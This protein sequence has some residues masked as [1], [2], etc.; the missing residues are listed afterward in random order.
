MSTL[1]VKRTRD[2]RRSR[3]QFAAVLVTITLGVMLFAASYDAYR[4]LRASYEGTYERLAFAD[5]TVTGG[6]ASFADSAVALPGV[7]EVAERRQADIPIRVAGDVLLG[8]VV[9]MP[10]D[11]QPPVDRIDVT[12]G[13]YLSSDTPSGVVVET[14]MA[15]ELG[16]RVGEPVGILVGSTWRPAEV[17]GIAVSPEY[18][19][20][21]RS[22]QDVFPA[23]GTFGVIF[24]SNDLLEGLPETAAARQTLILYAPAAD[25]SATDDAVLGAVRA[26]DGA[27]V[28][29]QADQPS[30]A[31]LQL[32]VQGF[33][34]LSIMFPALFL[35]AAG[36]AAY[37]LLTRIVY[38]QRGQIGTLRAN[39]LS[40]RAVSRHYLSF[41]V[42]LGA[43]GAVIGVALGVTFGWAMTGLYTKG[44]GIP[45][46]VRELHPVTPVVGLLFGL[47]CG[48]LAALVPARAVSKISPAQ[49][50]RVDTPTVA[51]RP[52]LFERLIP[53]LRRSPVRWLMILRGVGRSKR[54]SISTLVGV[55]L[56]LTLILVSWGMIDTVASVI[57]RQ[58]EQVQLEDATIV[59]DRPVTRA[60]VATVAGVPGVAD[61]EPVVDLTVSVRSDG[62][63]YATELRAFERSTRLHGFPDGLPADGVLAGRALRE[64]LAVDVGDEVTLTFPELGTSIDTQ[65][66]GFV[67]EPVGTFLYMDQA[68]LDAS[69]PSDADR[70]TLREPTISSIGAVFREDAGRERLLHDLRTLD[71]VAAVVD[72]RAL[73]DLVQEYLGFF[74]VFVGVM[75]AFGGAM[76]FALIFNTISVNV[77]ERST[78]YATMRANGMSNR[79]IAR[80][81]LGENMLLTGLGIVPGLVIGW[82][83]AALFMAE[84]SSDIFSFALDMRPSTLVLSALAMFV[85]AGLSLIP[86]LRTV[87]RIDVGRIVRE[88]AI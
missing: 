68:A 50:M 19:W 44:L 23:P 22:R 87:R 76:A 14:H 5:A 2:F 47:F 73:Y 67:D 88:R 32:D 24:A 13:T 63:T 12:D 42:I 62:D 26:E 4:N 16:L 34:E 71:G 38:S 75:L 58:F 84:Y 77:T 86:A 29:L 35:L 59:L 18:L 11:R 15:S 80:L 8:R 49:A 20:P 66:A 60:E 33:E 41:G 81:I 79:T 65:I 21:A 51:D 39:G 85:V 57:H 9:G 72:A 25:R 7:A 30:N 54:R 74:Y 31:T 53:P 52:S 82:A 1:A 10:P 43:A 70:R 17:V 69:L 48:S 37:I 83:V 6:S 40:R 55:I 46:T 56:A 64:V 28:L 78:E 27:S 3:W 61:A 45:D 36:M